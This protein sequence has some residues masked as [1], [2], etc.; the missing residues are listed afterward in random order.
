MRLH[1][2]DVLPYSGKVLRLPG[3]APDLGCPRVS[4]GASGMLQGQEVGGGG[5]DLE[6]FKEPAVGLDLCMLP[7][8][9][10]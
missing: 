5:I 10:S 7:L 3:K 1:S 6:P 9:H 8:Q 2:G 4:S